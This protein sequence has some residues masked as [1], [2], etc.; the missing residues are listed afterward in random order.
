MGRGRVILRLF[1]VLPRMT[2]KTT[3]TVTA[4]NYADLSLGLSICRTAEVNSVL[5]KA[6]YRI[7]YY[8]G[9]NV[10]SQA[11]VEPPLARKVNWDELGVDLDDLELI[12]D[13]VG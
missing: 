5:T 7:G 8:T 4:C 9:D 3:G 6:I 13:I 2:L 10:A 12:A 11:Q 1:P